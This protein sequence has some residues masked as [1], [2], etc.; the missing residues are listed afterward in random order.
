M[1]Y[2]FQIKKAEEL[3]STLKQAFQ[4]VPP[5]PGTEQQMDPAMAAQMDP[6]MAAQMDPAM[7]AQMQ[8]GGA[9]PPA[10]PQAGGDPGQMEAMLSEVMSAMEQI[11]GTVER[12]QQSAAKLEGA[13][14]GIGQQ[15]AQLSA[16]LDMIE[17]A[18]NA[19]S[20]ME[21]TQGNMM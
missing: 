4:P 6:A 9:P 21:G 14:Q 17:K 12:Q 1:D 19:S 10:P 15:S 5:P 7:A 2:N 16:R 8:Q 13:L 18:L 11:A 3:I 20:P